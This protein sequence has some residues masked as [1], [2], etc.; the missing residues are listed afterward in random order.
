M[1]RVITLSFIVLALTTWA[2]PGTAHA[3]TT[4][5]ATAVSPLAFGNVSLTGTTDAVTSFNI[6]CTTGSVTVLGQVKVNLC[7]SI[8]AGSTG[9]TAYTPRQM[10]NATSDLL[11]YQIYQDAAR[12]QIWGGLNITA[13]PTPR[14][15][16]FDYSVLLIGGSQT[17]SNI[18][19]YGRV[20]SGQTLSAGSYASA[21][22]GTQV[23]MQ[24]S[25]NEPIVGGSTMPTSCTSGGS[26]YKTANGAFPFNVT[27]TVPAQCHTYLTTDLDF[28][29]VAGS[30][31]SA[32]DGT[33][34]FSMTCTH[35]TSW[36][37][38]LN[39]GSN[40]NGT[41]RRM[42]QGTQYVNYELYR[43]SA[44]TSRWGSTIGTD[45]TNGT[46]T[47][48]TQSLT[49]YGRVPAGQTPPAGSYNDT[50][51]VTITY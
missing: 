46:G 45:T 44:R 1:S 33:S 39:N 11:Q 12:S 27:A 43:D 4:C 2:L 36:N 20:P 6:T 35:R 37:I 47:G 5:T 18:T 17:I 15:V 28:G 51:T 24:Y 13:A 30:I 7:L 34:N 31:N 23:V 42:R 8:G 10:T 41:T 29:N 32:I 50:V 40:A 14:V 3:N 16:Q 21:F 19:L 25:Y 49:I 48:S 38:G 22:S 26:G 9:G